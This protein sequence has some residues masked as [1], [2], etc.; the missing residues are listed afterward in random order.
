VQ[1]ANLTASPED[2]LVTRFLR[3]LHVQLRSIR[4]YQ[5]NHPRVTE[6]LVAMERDL[7]AVFSHCSDFGI[8][9][10]RGIL[11]F[12]SRG[13]SSE[14]TLADPRGELRA[15]AEELT[16]ADVH[17]LVFLPPTNLGELAL[18]A[19]AVDATSRL[20]EQSPA[21]LQP[22]ARDW[23]AWLTTHEVAGIRVNVPIERRS[24]PILA[25]LLGALLAR[26][27]AEPSAIKGTAE[28]AR[29]ALRFLSDAA[30]RLEQ[31]QRESP[32]NAARTIQATLSGA[33]PQALALVAREIVADPPTEGDTPSA[34]LARISNLL[35]VD[36]VKNEYLAGL[37]RTTEIPFVFE[38]LHGLGAVDDEAVFAAR[39]ERFWSAL[40][41][42]EKARV[43]ASPE[44]WCIPVTV[45]RSYLEPLIAAAQ[46]NGAQAS[47]RQARRT[48]AD[49]AR[50]LESEEEKARR[51]VSTTL[52]ELADLLEKLW[53]HPQLAGLASQVV[54]ALT[55]EHSPGIAGL[56]VAV[57][58]NLARLALGRQAYTEVERILE[59]LGQAPND[60][61]H[62]HI[63]ALAD[64]IVAQE[65]WLVLVDESL[66]N[67]PLDPALPRLLRRD[68]R[69][70]VDRL[71]LLLTAPE[72]V[73]A[74]PAMARLVRAAGEP[75][76]GS[77]VA[78][79][80]EPRHQRVATAIK[81][82][83]AVEPQRLVA[84][85]PRVLPSWDWN[86]QDL[87]VTELARQPSAALRSQAAEVWLAALA[88]VHLLV[89][90]SMLDQIALAGETSAVPHLVAIA[91]G[92]VERLRDPFVRIKAVEALGRLRA[93][94]AAELL[95][96][97]VRQRA[98]LL[99][100]LEPAGLR[101]AAEEALAL[102][103]NHPASTRLRAAQE[104]AAK[105][106][107]AFAQPRRYIRV[108]LP[109]PLLTKISAPHAA[110]ARVRSFALGGALL[111]TNARLAVGDSI[112]IEIRMGLRRI[113]LT[114][115]VRN[116]SRAGY[117]I[118]FVHMNQEDRERLRRR[119]GKLLR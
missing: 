23:P 47:G 9:I 104:K 88:E 116:A 6:S 10:E 89:V 79:L 61:E 41:A 33:D 38:R 93:P 39:I 117:G 115:V 16:R 62:G 108:A 68:P 51:A 66:A 30:P 67:R 17:S 45:L 97:L 84:I 19:N 3:S 94:E 8:R 48:L 42:R 54:A 90:P 101:S 26:E 71:G 53:P 21:R 43:L 82:L 119:V 114:A 50:C 22:Q 60:A 56:L 37:I 72:G 32:Q 36:F 59:D 113:P 83:S 7:R 4:L 111:E 35:A 106:S 15:L 46:S 25:S 81:L 2:F 70:L 112:R 11:L 87:A 31:A 102:I 29:Q 95:R 118:E 85:L 52:V 18:F 103:E 96:N 99:T 64:R 40:P 34:Y 1:T 28:M 75:V 13:A 100:Y 49:L 55:R 73:N 80:C 91:A 107:A 57:V 76:I 109:T 12:A 44:A 78:Q 77:L 105:S 24:E 27:P 92:D 74:L 69:R 63:A 110:T 5:R 20:T 58:E 98:G 86:L 14:R 65:R